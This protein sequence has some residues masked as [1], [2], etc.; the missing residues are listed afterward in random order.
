[1]SEFQ[2]ERLLEERQTGIG[3]SDV[4]ALMNEPPFGCRRR[5]AF[6]KLDAPRDYE[7][8]ESSKRFMARGRR[9]EEVV[10]EEYTAQTH[11]AARRTPVRRMPGAEH[12]LVHY[13]R[14]LTRV[15]DPPEGNALATTAPFEAKV[16]GEH[17]F[18][19][20]LNDGLSAD[21]ILQGQWGMLVGDFPWMG[22]GVFWADQWTLLHFD[23]TRNDELTRLLA[24]AA[25][26]FW[27]LIA[28]LRA[29]MAKGAKV[30]ELALPDRLPAGDDRCEHCPWRR[31]CW[32]PRIVEILAMVKAPK[33]DRKD[34]VPAPELVPVLTD[35][36]EAKQ[37][38]EAHEEAVDAIGQSLREQIGERQALI[39]GGN[40]VYYRMPK[41][42]VSLD[43][44]AM[45]AALSPEALEYL[46][47]NFGR[48]RKQSRTLRLY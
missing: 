4:A 26:S 36:L 16:P 41:P 47:R 44:D 6:L 2:E 10:A 34:L 3:G 14:L 29:E 48:A 11:R 8:S 38:L 37:I 7:D 21:Y 45:R 30:A 28:L 25:D 20:V 5:L 9:L 39:V 12:R 31:T 13:D 24:D 17:G 43:M 23:V 46:F 15:A 22:F 32:G 19:R 35:Y 42:S 27:K 40:T 1:M 33:E 18:K